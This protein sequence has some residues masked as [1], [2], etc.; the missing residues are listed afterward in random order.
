MD[1]RR[2]NRVEE[3]LEGIPSATNVFKDLVVAMK[4]AG[5]RVLIVDLRENTGGN[6]LMVP[7]LLYFLFGEGSMVFYDEG[8][9]ISRYSE[10]YFSSICQRITG[11]DQ[12]RSCGAA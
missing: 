4:H 1:R 5:T 6:D 7:M 11:A 12:P 2:L 3:I 10:L 9:Q 8:F